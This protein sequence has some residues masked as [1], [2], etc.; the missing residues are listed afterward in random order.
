MRG[1]PAL[2]CR[3]KHVRL[4]FP[5][6]KCRVMHSP[7]IHRRVKKALPPLLGFNPMFSPAI[8]C[9]ER[10]IKLLSELFP[11]EGEVPRRGDG[12]KKHPMFSNIMP[13][14]PLKTSMFSNK[15]LLRLLKTSMFSNMMP[16]R[17]LKPSMFSNK[18]PLRP[19]KA[20]MFE[21]IKKILPSKPCCIKTLSYFYGDAP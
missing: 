9:R 4:G 16:L 10:S 19:F 5:A 15:M 17:L 3:A 2:K 11:C 8:Y 1:V 13:L 14:S 18:T 20:S 12:V 7:A 6:L 21:N